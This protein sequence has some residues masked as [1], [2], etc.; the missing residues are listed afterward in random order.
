MH[1]TRRSHTQLITEVIQ[2]VYVRCGDTVCGVGHLSLLLRIAYNAWLEMTSAS[3]QLAKRNNC[4]STSVTKQSHI[5]VQFRRHSTYE[6]TSYV[7]SWLIM[8]LPSLFSSLGQIKSWMPSCGVYA[9]Q[10]R[11][12][13][14]NGVGV[15][16]NCSINQVCESMH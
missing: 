11:R 16:T 6:L 8:Q 7:D 1:L 10:L 13:T 2:W 4:L 12:M 14:L 9:N 5:P 15:G 3:Q